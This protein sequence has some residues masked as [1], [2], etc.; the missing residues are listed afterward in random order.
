MP[1][2][3]SASGGALLPAVSADG[4]TAA[5]AT[6]EILLLPAEL[7][8]AI[9]QALDA[10]AGTPDVAPESDQA[11][12]RTA[13]A[14]AFA[15][16]LH[17]S[18]LLLIEAADP[19]STQSVSVQTYSLALAGKHTVEA[20]LE[21]VSRVVTGWPSVDACRQPL[22]SELAQGVLALAGRAPPDD[23]RRLHGGFVRLRALAALLAGNP[24]DGWDIRS[25]APLPAELMDVFE[26]E[27]G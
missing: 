18:G 4:A 12:A 2:D 14:G 8:A 15:Q 11:V 9:D 3:P 21:A 27:I 16:A 25:A 23:R 19:K 5:L 10:L 20:K 6:G 7:W 24:T 26:G 22:L 17:R 13:F 1:R